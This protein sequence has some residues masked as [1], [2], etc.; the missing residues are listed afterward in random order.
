MIWIEGSD[1]RGENVGSWWLNV[2]GNQNNDFQGSMFEDNNDGPGTFHVT[3]AVFNFCDGHAE[4]HRWQNGA[5]VAFGN[6]MTG[7][8]PPPNADSLWV[9][10]HYPGKQ[11]P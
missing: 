8:P 1:T 3:A 11:N 5:T 9:A 2:Q 6:A 4:S 10:Q 7:S